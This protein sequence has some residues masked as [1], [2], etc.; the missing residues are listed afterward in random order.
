MIGNISLNSLMFSFFLYSLKP[1]ENTISAFMGAFLEEY[2]VSVL[3][4][5]HASSHIDCMTLQ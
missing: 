5:G 4:F 3:L 1:A 2:L